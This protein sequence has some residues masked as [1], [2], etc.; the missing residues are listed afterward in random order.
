MGFFP[1]LFSLRSIRKLRRTDRHP[2]ENNKA[3]VKVKVRGEKLP[4][5]LKLYM[6]DNSGACD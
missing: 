4:E 5:N 2:E 6:F 1:Q 3:L